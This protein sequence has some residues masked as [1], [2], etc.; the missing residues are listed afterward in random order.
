MLSLAKLPVQKILIAGVA[1]LGVLVIAQTTRL[2]SAQ[3]T[4]GKL[5]VVVDAAIAANESNRTTIDA[6]RVRI[7]DLLLLISIN[8]NLAAAAAA[9][10]ML[11]REKLK[12]ERDNAKRER[13]ELFNSSPGCKELARLDLAMCPAVVDRLR[14]LSQDIGTDEDR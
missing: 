11:D 12:R 7:N 5:G 6:Q 14:G 8:K 1:V 9:Q 2:G 10:N 13:D 4:I 3:E